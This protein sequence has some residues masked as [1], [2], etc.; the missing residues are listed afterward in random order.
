MYSNLIELTASKLKEK[1]VSFDNGLSE[2]EFD[3]IKS[4]FGI[5]FPPDLKTFL[6]KY[7][8]TSE[9]FPHWRASVKSEKEKEKI[10]NSLAWP[11]EGILFHIRTGDYWNEAWGNKPKTKEEQKS[12]AIK[13]FK[14]YPI[15]IPIYSHR[16]IPQTPSED[17]NPIFSVYS[18]DIIYY[19]YDLW[20]YFANEF[21]Y[22]LPETLGEITYPK[23]IKFWS[24]FDPV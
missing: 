22:K 14:N 24:E 3:K 19:G 15:L 4:I 5:S 13:A 6:S 10:D 7:L 2:K 12:I 8:P 17:A 18:S 16:Y 9:G 21:G 20:S 1:G 11:L 23:E